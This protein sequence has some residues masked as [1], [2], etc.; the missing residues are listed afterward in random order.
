MK[1]DDAYKPHGVKAERCALLREDLF[2][3]FLI[4]APPVLL[5]WTT[6]R[7]EF[8]RRYYPSIPLSSIGGFAPLPTNDKSSLREVSQFQNQSCQNQFTAC[9]QCSFVNPTVLS[10]LTNQSSPTVLFDL[11]ST[12]KGNNTFDNPRGSVI[13]FANPV[14]MGQ[15]SSNPPPASD[16]M[17]SYRQ[18]KHLF[19]VDG[20]TS[21]SDNTTDI[22]MNCFKL[23]SE[24]DEA[25]QQFLNCLNDFLVNQK[26]VTKGKIQLCIVFS[27]C[28]CQTCSE[29][30]GKTSKWRC[31]VSS[32]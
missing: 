11:E 15:L 31:N 19:Q 17:T 20:A 24:S 5:P 8:I 26:T 18:L 23:I 21:S 22:W 28:F 10:N 16:H 14:E 12:N 6:E 30:I 7:V 1:I 9:Q 3:L 27:T 2:D 25:L 4:S 29:M 32:P 13:K